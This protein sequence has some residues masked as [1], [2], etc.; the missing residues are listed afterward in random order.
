M[1]LERAGAIEIESFEKVFLT[2]SSAL[3]ASEEVRAEITGDAYWAAERFINAP[4]S[5][6]ED[7]VY[8]MTDIENQIICTEAHEEGTNDR[9]IEAMEAFWRV[10][11]P[12]TGWDRV[13]LGATLIYMQGLIDDPKNDRDR[14]VKLYK[15]LKILDAHIQVLLDV[16]L[17]SEEGKACR[18][19][20]GKYFG[21]VKSMQKQIDDRLDALRKAEKQAS[22]QCGETPADLCISL[23]SLSGRESRDVQADQAG[24]QAGSFRPRGLG[25]AA[26]AG[27]CAGR[28]HPRG[29]TGR[30]A[31]MAGGLG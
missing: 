12:M 29:P 14:L 9:M 25:K 4:E 17:S 11:N 3:M 2:Y 30:R 22:E 28:R 5:V 18:A 21:M 7:M 13:P 20:Y 16:L 24:G 23:Q 31:C 27:G 6:D 19:V 15:K 10:H 26:S 1:G 8:Y